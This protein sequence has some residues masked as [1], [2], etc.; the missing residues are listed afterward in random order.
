M[1]AVYGYI[2]A[3]LLASILIT[4]RPL[5]KGRGL[6]FTLLRLILPLALVLGAGFFVGIILLKLDVSAYAAQFGSTLRSWQGQMPAFLAFLLTLPISWL[7]ILAGQSGLWATLAFILL[8]MWIYV[9]VRL[10]FF[11]LFGI[12][13]LVSLAIYLVKWL[14]CLLLSRPRPRRLKSYP[15]VL[16]ESAGFLIPSVNL[17][18]LLL[19]VFLAA[20]PYASKRPEIETFLAVLFWGGVWIAILEI[21]SWLWGSHDKGSRRV[22]G[23]D[24]SALEIERLEELYYE[25]Q[26]RHPDQI[27]LAWDEPPREAA[28]RES[29]FKESTDPSDEAAEAYFRSTCSSGGQVDR[30]MASLRHFIKGGDLLFTDTLSGLHYLL[31]SYFIRMTVE[32]GGSAFILCPTGT[33]EEVIAAL[34][35]R[36]PTAFF[37]YALRVAVFGKDQ[38]GADFQ[39]DVL[40]CPENR[41]DGLMEGPLFENILGSCSLFI[42]LGVEKMSLSSLRYR[43]IR[44]RLPF[45][46]S[47]IQ[48]LF[49]SEVP[50]DAESSVRELI[51]ARNILEDRLNPGGTVRRLLLLWRSRG[52][53]EAEFKQYYLKGYGA[54]VDLPLL[55]CWLPFDRDFSVTYY[56]PDQRFDEDLFERLK[57]HVSFHFSG[58]RAHPEDWMQLERSAFGYTHSGKIVVVAEDVN[59]LA[60]AVYRSYNFD[61]GSIALVCLASHNYLL[62]DFMVACFHGQASHSTYRLSDEL[63]QP[64]VPRACGGLTDLAKSLRSCLSSPRGLSG[65]EITC[66]LQAFPFK[67][68]LDDLKIS[69]SPD[70][71]QRLFEEAFGE[72]CLITVQRIQDETRYI[73]PAPGTGAQEA[74]TLKNTLDQVMGTVS[75]GDIG[76]R[77]AEDT[78][79]IL[80][81]KFHRISKIGPSSGDVMVDH[82]DDDSYKRF[83]YFFDRTYQINEFKW[84]EDDPI[85]ETRGGLQ[86]KI[87]HWHVHFTRTTRGYIEV[88]EGLRPLDQNTPEAYRHLIHRNFQNPLS[89]SKRWRNLL[90]MRIHSVRATGKTDDLGRIA[91]TLCAL[92]QDTI[93]SLTPRVADKVA[94]MSPQ[95]AFSQMQGT[96]PGEARDSLSALIYP[97]IEPANLKE[98][99]EGPQE[100]V[101]YILE[102]ADEDLGVIRTLKDDYEKILKVVYDYLVWASGQEESDLYHTFGAQTL[103][104]DFDYPSVKAYL[105]QGFAGRIPPATAKRPPIEVPPALVPE[106]V[107]GKFCDFCARPLPGDYEKIRDGRLICK[108]CSPS[109]VRNLDEFRRIFNKVIRQM[110]RRYRITLP[111]DFDT[112]FVSPEE[113]AALQGETFVPT[114][115]FDPR[116]VGLAM[117]E[118]KKR[119][120]L[121]ENNAPRIATVATLAHELT[122][123]WQFTQ[124]GHE[125]TDQ[126]IL[127]GQARYIEIDFSRAHGGRRL[128]DMLESQA[129]TGTDIYARGWRKVVGMCSYTPNHVFR[130]FEE[131]FRQW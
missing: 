32:R 120:M 4:F 35:S 16:P 130:C 90:E 65:D 45:P 20:L 36:L 53:S 31:I 95:S 56:D 42:A 86:F 26:R 113:I 107:Q 33:D 52:K 15:V 14:Y 11:G 21:R 23:E 68:L 29:P 79:I 112:R 109:A 17:A 80:G 92:L 9:F 119:T 78:Y 100:L 98:G 44:F 67:G 38:V 7:D 41:F 25:Y 106:K 118:G 43:L 27:L 81:Q 62:R 93:F 55:L 40:I 64:R 83:R 5:P 18:T 73:C 82:Q 77:M 94:V 54:S 72:E 127:E 8:F 84:Q 101:L 123:I 129:R 22:S 63:L 125:K 50:G 10:G 1:M 117:R 47:Q 69:P 91:F 110:E 124:K 121:L 76:L 89:Y 6:L 103:H 2:I 87:A 111:H 58:H 122:H 96:A 99:K 105:E 51:P 114:D 37:R 57:N 131:T 12:L 46:K 74:L 48:F 70:G 75:A 30:L 28:S 3:F 39:P 60:A 49:Q 126:E 34:Q 104:P 85:D 116:A 24:V 19:A 13:I 115:G 66:F 59:N 108:R 88:A 128:A 102:D 71:M 61:S 97:K